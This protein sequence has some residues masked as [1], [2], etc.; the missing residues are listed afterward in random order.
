MPAFEVARS[1]LKAL[2]A[3][4]AHRRLVS[5]GWLPPAVAAGTSIG[6]S[7]VAIKAQ[8]GPFPPRR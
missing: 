7:D 8:A 3:S 1:H 2:L 6:V 4:S 5:S